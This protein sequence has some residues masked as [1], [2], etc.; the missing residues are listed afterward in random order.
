VPIYEIAALKESVT[1]GALECYR[2]FG[3]GLARYYAQDWEGALTL[4][5]RS[6]ELEPNQPGK[7]PG[8]QS[9]PSLVYLDITA[10]FQH[11]PP[12]QPWDGVYVMKE[13]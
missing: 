4:F 6:A 7:T 12:P 13:K 11:E 9:N 2:I 3:E 1:P 5:R 8:V 10:H